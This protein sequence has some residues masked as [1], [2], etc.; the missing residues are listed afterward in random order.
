M[1]NLSI[2]TGR[3][4]YGIDTVVP[5][6][7]YAS[8]ERCPARG[9]KPLSANLDEIRKLPGI[10]DAFL[11]EGGGPW[12]AI[13]TSQNP[14][15][16]A[17]V[18][19][20]TWAVF[21]A[22]R[23]LKVTW[24][25]STGSRDSSTEIL[26]LARE[27]ALKP[28]AAVL[29]ESGNVEA[30]FAAAR[31]TVS[32]FYQYAHVSHAQMEPQNTVAHWKD[33]KV[34][35]WAPTQAPDLAIPAVAGAVG[36]K[37]EDVTVH[38]TR[39]GGGFGR[40]LVNDYACEAAA[41]SKHVNAPVKLQWTREDDIQNDFYRSGGCH[42][43]KAA[44]DAGGK[45]TALQNHY[46][47]VTMDGKSAVIG[48]GLS[49]TEFPATFVPNYRAWQTLVKT[50]I[51]FGPWRAPGS[52]VVAWA[53]QSFLHELSTAAKRDHVEFLLEQFANQ[54]PGS[55]PAGPGGPMGKGIEP[56]RA[57]GVIRMAAEK[58]AGARGCR[59]GQALGIAFHFSHAGHFAEVAR[60]SVDAN[61]R[62][63][64]HEVTVVG[65][66]GPIVNLS[67]VE[68]QCQGSV[69]DGLSAM[70]G[71]EIT[72]ENGRIQ[73]TNFQNYPLLRISSAPPKINV[74]FIQTEVP[75]TGCGE[76]ALPPL[77]PAV[78]NAIFT[79]TGHRVRT[80]PLAKEGYSI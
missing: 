67:S 9:G 73:Q 27:Q 14:P 59:K 39:I 57:I 75:P 79:L 62:V 1:D 41:I 77:A 10:K 58:A 32:A 21:S 69:V 68:N 55:P 60:V 63:T 22:R 54:Q 20:S 11:L 65:D 40:R 35:I 76:P 6:M 66:V 13:M 7:L 56:A 47:T 42:S 23:K 5:G 16:V 45:L 3:P 19:T 36:V 53:V 52:N 44:L 18:G 34:E 51:P 43:F 4:L 8:L 26:N 38:V 48:G 12:S 46:F 71:Q 78:C 61:K 17:V 28:G 37:P 74:H 72:F 25:E 15:G 30:A 49:P 24:D 50:V 31:Q 33:G 70:M 80:L 29:R 64:V 2:V